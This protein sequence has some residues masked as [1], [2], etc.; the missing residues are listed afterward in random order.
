[1]IR[2]QKVLKSFNGHMVLNNLSFNIE[3]NTIVSILGPSGIGKTT[4]LQLISGTIRPDFGVVEVTGKKIGYIFQD[5]RLLPWRTARDNVALGLIAEGK[6]R[7]ESRKIATG[8]I[9]KL[10]LEG[11]EDHYPGELSGGMMQRVSIGRALAI[12]PDILLM[13]EPFSNL[14]L[15]LKK[16]LMTILESIFQE[17]QTT[18][19]YV[20]HD[21]SE[22]VRI[23][24]KILNIL[25]N[26]VIKEIQQDDFQKFM[27]NS[28]FDE[29]DSNLTR[30]RK[31]QP[32]FTKK[33]TAI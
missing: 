10:G 32:M 8:W 14:N 19:V 20:T 1:M 23:S 6:P 22:A 29:Y 17:C 12:E 27:K 13:D 24:D 4:I 18:V 7:D 15:E 25:P 26:F 28:C 21:I 2:F 16:T 5:P 3:K 30:K 31:K 9:K 33:V 11:F